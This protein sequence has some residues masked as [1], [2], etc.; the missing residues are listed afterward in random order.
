MWQCDKSHT[1]IM[2][3]I[4]NNDGE[5]TYVTAVGDNGTAITNSYDNDAADWQKEEAYNDTIQEC[6]DKNS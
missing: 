1:T 5:R 6:L 2:D 4:T 3:I